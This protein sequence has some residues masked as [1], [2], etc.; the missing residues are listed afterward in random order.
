MIGLRHG[1]V[2]AEE[3]DDVVEIVLLHLLR[4]AERHYVYQNAFSEFDHS[5]MTS[6]EKERRESATV[7]HACQLAAKRDA[8]DDPRWHAIAIAV[9]DVAD[10]VFGEVV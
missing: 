5:S 10:A 4:L 3:H 9:R 2:R 1:L 7:C 8:G 6:E